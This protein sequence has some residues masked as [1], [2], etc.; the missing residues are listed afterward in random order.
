V[1]V[2]HHRDVLVQERQAR[3][4]FQLR[5]RVGLERHAGRPGLEGHA[6]LDVKRLVHGG[7]AAAVVRRLRGLRRGHV[8][9]RPRHSS[10]RASAEGPRGDGERHGYLSNFIASDIVV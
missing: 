7:G 2:G 3:D 5:A 9:S 1:H 6:A 10:A 4:P 8:A